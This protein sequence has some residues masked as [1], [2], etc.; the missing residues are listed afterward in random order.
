MRQSRVLKVI[1]IVEDEDAAA[2]QVGEEEAAVAERSNRKE[3]RT[4][5]DEVQISLIS[6]ALSVIN[7][8]T[9]QQIVPI[10]F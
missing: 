1:I 10:K 6:H 7:K 9:T 3:K 2:D 5:K 8:D 4:D